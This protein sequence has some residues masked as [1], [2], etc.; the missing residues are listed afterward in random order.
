GA[1]RSWFSAGGANLLVSGVPRLS[2]ITSGMAIDSYSERTRSEGLFLISALTYKE[3]YVVDL[4]GR[5]DG[6][7]LFGPDERWQNYYRAALAWRMAQEPWWP[8]QSIQEF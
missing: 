2:L 1:D 5:R 4:L 3:R 7:S 8:F 6:S